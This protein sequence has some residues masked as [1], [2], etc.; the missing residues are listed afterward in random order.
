MSAV[1][2]STRRVRLH[3]PRVRVR[4]QR[5]R[6]AIAVALVCVPVLG[7]GWFL[8]RDSSFVAV[9][10][11]TITGAG[12]T[13]GPA[14][15]RALDTAARRMTTLDL[16][17]ARLRAAVSG[18]EEVTGLRVSA[19][20]PHG[21]VIHVIERL[22]VGVVL[23]FGRDTPV[24]GDGTLLPKVSSSS[25]LPLIVLAQPPRGARLRQPWSVGAARLLGAAP[26][27]LLPRLSEVMN[28]AGH[29]L[30]VQIRNGPS[31]YFGSEGQL[32]EKWTAVL[33]VLADAGS[34]G[35]SYIDVT[36][37]A[38]PAAGADSGTSTTASTASTTVGSAASTSPAS[39]AAASPGPGS[40]AAP[41]GG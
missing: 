40:A 31:I 15:H 10:H 5:V 18:F 24:A 27:R 20:F 14:I 11:V 32:Q 41:A 38:R 22:P 36:D 1:T 28:I 34:V 6:L 35:A 12:G 19:Q 25:S 26:R 16:N 23:S 37:P 4:R 7:G 9:E 17:A 39:A 8:L 2:T 30:V 13:D 21:L 33:A 29:G 3:L